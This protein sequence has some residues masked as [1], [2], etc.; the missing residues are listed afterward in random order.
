MHPVP[1]ASPTV[2]IA[3]GLQ[4][5]VILGLVLDRRARRKSLRSR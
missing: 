4:T 3:A 5:L 1:D 2:I